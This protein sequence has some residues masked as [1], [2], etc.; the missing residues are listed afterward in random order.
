MIIERLTPGGT[1]E[2]VEA[3]G[4]LPLRAE[5]IRRWIVEED[6]TDESAWA[7]RLRAEIRRKREE[8]QD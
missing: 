1:Y 6:T 4:F 3:S 2:P 7:R 8:G 5:E